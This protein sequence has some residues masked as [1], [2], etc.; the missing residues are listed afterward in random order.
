MLEEQVICFKKEILSR[1]LNNAGV[2]YDEVLWHNI[3]DNLQSIPRSV[4][5][6]DYDFKQLVV[7]L[8]IRSDKLFLTYRRTSR[9]NEERL[10]NR[11][12]LGIGGH[13]NTSDSS[14]LP[15]FD[16]GIREGFV[17]QALWREIKEEISIKSKVVGEPQL[18][19]FI[20]DD[21]DDVSKVHFGTVWLVE[22]EKPE[23][24]LRR[25]AGVGKLE[26]CSLEELQLRKEQFEKWSDL[27]IDYFSSGRAFP[28]LLT[29]SK[30]ATNS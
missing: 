22:L 3:L 13:I 16:S 20:N 12:S 18:L 29:S 23:V 14:Q 27:L 7:Y 19:C 28:F 8:V 1:H 24:S 4:A 5:E 17:L 2:F 25:E 15:L 6:N 10:R 26:F 21:S 30:P 11:Y 9:T